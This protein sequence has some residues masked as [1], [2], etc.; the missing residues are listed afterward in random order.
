M[1]W[2]TARYLA[3]ALEDGQPHTAHDLAAGA[4]LGVPAIMRHLRPMVKAGWVVRHEGRPPAFSKPPP[5][6]ALPPQRENAETFIRAA[7]AKLLDGHDPVPELSAAMAV[8]LIEEHVQEPGD[9]DDLAGW[10]E[11]IRD[12][13]PWL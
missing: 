13:A 1:S 5:P 3:G 10:A 12:G 6:P 11:S 2:N 7:L 9:L 4:G 8:L